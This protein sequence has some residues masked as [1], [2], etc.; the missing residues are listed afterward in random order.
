MM[1]MTEA[2]GLICAY[3]LDGQGGG[4]KVGWS[5][6]A[7]WTPDHGVLWVHL[8]RSVADSQQW[9][10]EASGLD[11]LVVEALLADETRPRSLAVGDG[12]L[13]NLRGVNLNPGADPEDMIAVRLWLDRS[14]VISTRARFLMAAKDI[15]DDVVAS[16]GPKD[17]GDF[18]V[19]I[20]GRLVARMGPVL[21]QLDDA[22]DAL[23]DELV[24]TGRR[25]IRHRLG[26]V[27]RETIGLRRYLA[28]QREAMTRL[29]AEDAEWL[30]PAH[31]ARLREVTDR[32]L[33]YVED[34]DAVRERAAV[35]QDELMSRASDQMNQ[36]VYVLT[37]VAAV[38]LP[39]DFVTGL[40]GVN[41][42]GMPGTDSP[43][44]FLV[45]CLILAVLA[46]GQIWLLRRF[47]WI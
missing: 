47:K 12:L 28:P 38:L 45:V 8:D 22:V 24:T 40:L 26:E 4:R 39:L 14:L 3:V 31:K 23:E 5:D 34:L 16:R 13:V 6:I 41:M 20:A 18:L 46:G 32:V 7:S 19:Q 44:A 17:A 11:P 21:D 35:V 2:T 43:Q 1:A 15:A 37:L 9:L 25:A 42:G 33:R 30:G 29:Q 10:R 36:R 27:R